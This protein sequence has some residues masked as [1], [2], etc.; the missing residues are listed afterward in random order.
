MGGLAGREEALSHLNPEKIYV[1]NVRSVLGVSAKE[2]ERICDA[3]ARQ[4]VFERC[5]EVLC[6]DGVV[7][8]AAESES[9]LPAQVPCW[10]EQE[11]HFEEIEVPVDTLQKR[12]YY[13]LHEQPATRSNR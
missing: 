7:A 12:V 2:A 13:R 1:E 4:G 8:A 3:A 5:V 11:G 6:P 9:G 10:S